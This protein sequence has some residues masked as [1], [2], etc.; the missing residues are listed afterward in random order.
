MQ[1]NDRI[2]AT[3]ARALLHTHGG[4][5]IVDGSLKTTRGSEVA[6]QIEDTDSFRAFVGPLGV[7]LHLEGARSTQVFLDMAVSKSNGI[8]VA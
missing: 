3:D 6:D 2:T 4:S 8:W 7:N 5:L 1:T